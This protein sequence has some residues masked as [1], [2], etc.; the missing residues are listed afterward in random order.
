M[1]HVNMIRANEIQFWD[2]FPPDM[3]K[4]AG[5]LGSFC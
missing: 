1:T 3:N 2:S 5:G 4:E